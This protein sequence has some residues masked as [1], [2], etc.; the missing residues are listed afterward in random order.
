MHHPWRLN[1]DDPRLDRALK[2]TMDYL[3][4]K[5]LALDRYSVQR[6]AAVLIYKEWRKGIRHPV[7]LADTVI[8][9]LEFPATTPVKACAG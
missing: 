3:A 4:A 5:G 6:A 7:R 9:Q 1:N 8:V 2:I